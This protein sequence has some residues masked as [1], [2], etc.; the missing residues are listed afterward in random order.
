MVK[1]AHEYVNPIPKKEVL[2]D[3]ATID[4]YKLNNLLKQCPEGKC[5][6]KIIQITV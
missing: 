2:K 6:L 3:K 4:K 5:M 1:Y